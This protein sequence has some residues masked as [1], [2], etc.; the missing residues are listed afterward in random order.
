[1]K[2][3]AR[4]FTVSM[5]TLAAVVMCP[6]PGRALTM[7]DLP[8][9]S[10]FS[11]RGGGSMGMG[12][13][14]IT[15]VEAYVPP[16]AAPVP[17]P[18]AQSPDP[19]SPVPPAGATG[20]KPLGN[21]SGITATPASRPSNTDDNSDTSRRPQARP[22]RGTGQRPAA[23]GL[24]PNPETKST[25]ALETNGTINCG[26]VDADQLADLVCNQY[27]TREILEDDIERSRSPEYS[28]YTDDAWALLEAA[29]LTEGLTRPDVLF[30]SDVNPTFHGGCSL[31]QANA[32]G[33]TFFDEVLE[34]QGEAQAERELALTMVHEATHNADLQ[35]NPNITPI[36]TEAHAGQAT[37]DAMIA[38][39]YPEEAIRRQE[40]IAGAFAVLADNQDMLCD[41]MG[42][43][44]P[45]GCVTA[46]L[47]AN[48]GEFDVFISPTEAL[49][50]VSIGCAQQIVVVNIETGSITPVQMEQRG[51]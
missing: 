33:I 3:P 45:P 27:Y 36:E 31:W 2:V 40:L 29:G 43:G 48:N 24:A 12:R 34:E 46:F 39:G 10:D 11:I 50:T 35:N 4:F 30:M 47:G 23:P 51:G 16:A 15:P 7:P 14:F 21:A 28:G 13:G 18:A 44:V 9:D 20:G 17:A 19:A 5:L 41:M 6:C 38:L 26:N 42:P 49:M 25:D 22:A 8:G 1:M 32:M 37:T